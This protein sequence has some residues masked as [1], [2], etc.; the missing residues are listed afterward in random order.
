VEGTFTCSYD[1]GDSFV[2]TCDA[3]TGECSGNPPALDWVSYEHNG[4]AAENCVI[5]AHNEWAALPCS[6]QHHFMCE[7]LDPL[8]E[9]CAEGWTMFTSQGSDSCYQIPNCKFILSEVRFGYPP[10]SGGG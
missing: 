7:Y 6:E 10:A 2:T 9:P 8:G 5:L 1:A 4:G 3:A